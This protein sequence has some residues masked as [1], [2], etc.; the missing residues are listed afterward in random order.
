MIHPHILRNCNGP[1]QADGDPI[2]GHWGSVQLLKQA[3]SNSIV[4]G[5]D[6]TWHLRAPAFKEHVVSGELSNCIQ[7]QIK[8]LHTLIGPEAKKSTTHQ[9]LH[10]PQAILDLGNTR[11]LTSYHCISCSLY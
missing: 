10:L 5:A 7:Q 11:S 1:E 2:Y 4:S 3:V 6:A 9:A 8:D